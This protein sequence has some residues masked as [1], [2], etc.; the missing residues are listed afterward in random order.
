MFK[1]RYSAGKEINYIANLEK[2]MTS[3]LKLLKNEEISGK[4]T[5][6]KIKPVVSRPGILYGLGK[7]QK[8]IKNGLPPFRP[9][10]S[11]IGTPVYKLATFLPP[12]LAS[13]T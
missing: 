10:L 9:I 5:Y 6:K 13:L 2:R 4:T 1:P 11:G 8:E 3:D 7:V 12:F